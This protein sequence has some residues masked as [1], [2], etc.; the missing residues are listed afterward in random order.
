[1]NFMFYVCFVA[2]TENMAAIKARIKIDVEATIDKRKPF[3]IIVDECDDQS[4]PG[5]LVNIEYNS[6]PRLKSKVLAPVYI[7]H[8]LDAI[9]LQTMII[10]TMQSYGLKMKKVNG[11]Y[12]DSTGYVQ[13]CFSNLRIIYV[14]ATDFP[15]PSHLLALPMK[16]LLLGSTKELSDEFSDVYDFII[17]SNQHFSKSKERKNDYR[18]AIK[19]RGLTVKEILRVLGDMKIK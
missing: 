19:Q 2:F 3:N 18:Q 14:F 11:F 8:S 10:E 15:D 6:D 5:G 17:K 13:K 4:T 7:K 1:M 12:G 9:T 16:N